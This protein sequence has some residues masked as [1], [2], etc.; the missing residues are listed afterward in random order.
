MM[1]SRCRVMR[2]LAE[3]KREGVILGIDPGVANT[4]YAILEGS[5]D[6]V[7]LKDYGVIRTSQHDLLAARLMEIEENVMELIR[8]YA[9][10]AAAVETL[11]FTVNKKTALNVAHAR[12]VILR[13]LYV[14]SLRIAEY[15]PLQVKKAITGNG[16]ATKRDVQGMLGVL[17]GS[18]EAI[19]QDD[20]ADAVAVALCHSFFR[21]K[22][23]CDV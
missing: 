9:P 16:K 7:Q 11:F 14:C 19:K 23:L 2:R 15:S 8:S 12:G 3:V 4:G 21:E 22:Q 17:L 10:S 6:E 13:T 18:N 5:G 1:C 20:A